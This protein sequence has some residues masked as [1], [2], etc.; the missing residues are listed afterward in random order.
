MM[1]LFSIFEVLSFSFKRTIKFM[2]S[3][4]LGILLVLIYYLS[5]VQIYFKR[6][7]KVFAE[8][9]Y[10]P[11]IKTLFRLTNGLSHIKW[12]LIIVKLY[13][14]DT[15]LNFNTNF[16]NVD[17]VPISKDKK[18]AA[19]D[20]YKSFLLSRTING[21]LNDSILCPYLSL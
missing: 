2:F 15:V 18:V 5:S 7:E 21:T 10:S 12:H 20:Y 4:S 19:K 14:N 16:N 11:I 3:C 1:D 8:W 17:P 13:I 6:T 9:R